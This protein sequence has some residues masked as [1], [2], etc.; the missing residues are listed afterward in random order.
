MSAKGNPYQLGPVDNPRLLRTRRREIRRTVG[1]VAPESGH[2]GHALVVGD[3]RTGRTSVLQEVGRRARS[4]RSSLVVPLRLLEDDLTTSGLPRAL[5]NATVESLVEDVT[6]SPDWYLAWCDR[7]HLRD[8][9]RAG[10]RDLL[11]SALALAA[12]GVAVLDS[13]VLH[14]DLRTLSRLATE[15]GCNRIVVCIDDADAL[16]EDVS[17]VENLLNAVDVV[18][19]WSFVMTTGPAG[20]E[21]LVEAVSPCLRRF[22]TIGLAPFWTQDEV[23]AC[24]TAPL[25]PQDAQRLLPDNRSGLLM[26]LLRLTGGNP[27]EIALTA[28]HLWMA[29]RLGEQEHYE[30][31]P[32]VLQR[33]L[34]D[35]AMYTGAEGELVDGA[36]AVQQ[37][38]RNEIG[39]ALDLV[40]LSKLTTRQIAIARLLGVPNSA[41]AVNERLQTADVDDAERR[42]VE[43]LEALQSKG[44]VL[45]EEGGG[46]TVQGGKRAAI[47]LKYEARS[48]LGPEAA[49]KPFGVPF[50][51]CVGEPLAEEYARRVVETVPGARRLAWSSE[52]SSASSSSGARLRAALDTKPFIGLDIEA[53]AFSAEAHERMTDLVIDPSGAAIVVIDFTLTCEDRAFD[54]LEVWE[55]PSDLEHH[56]IN[57]A[58]SDALDEW[59]LLVAAADLRWQGSHAA[60]FGSDGLR[61]ALT[62]LCPPVAS[63]AVYRLWDQWLSGDRSVP[64]DDALAVAESTVEALREHRVPDWERGWELST[65]LSHKGFLLSLYP[66]RVDA[67]RDALTQ[68]RS[69]GPADGW[70]TLW[71]LA[72]IAA[73]KGEWGNAQQLLDALGD[74]V[75]V[76]VAHL[77]FFVP[78]RQPVSTVV[79]VDGASAPAL[80]SL[81]RAL[82]AYLSG[83]AVLEEL[84]A[85]LDSC[86]DAG[87][88]VAEAATWVAES[89]VAQLPG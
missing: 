17:L 20:Y 71:N 24:L 47:A 37:L 8:R 15:G 44:V 41:N 73:R 19:N 22:S 59:Q 39:A 4:E 62:Q 30:L 78:G 50:L 79:R 23:R 80:V 9:S 26:D 55:V 74:D 5:L 64:P 11:V 18:G 35:L 57:Q 6:P 66:D 7:V 65:A 16:L 1:V 85:A 83:E 77:L 49:E 29:C 36:R 81:Q 61:R 89:I 52:F 43:E 68:A 88:V 53:F 3:E 46:F 38:D 42:V 32:R 14:R 2:G 84:R 31:T 54:W 34:T 86:A 70:V 72:N 12:D 63:S 82:V 33:A 69:R 75:Q 48:L 87:D 21:H 58:V 60:R 56:D 25:D 51:P 27:F 45:L 28:R 40:A 76:T 10:V 67:A 13:A